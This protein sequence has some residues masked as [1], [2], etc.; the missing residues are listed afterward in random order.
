M[1]DPVRF[2]KILVAILKI[3]IVVELVGALWQ[4]MKNGDWGRFG[5][6][7]VI[8]GI[9]YVLWGRIVLLVRQKKEESRKKVLEP[10][11]RTRLWDALIFSLLWSDEIYGGIP[12]DRKRLVVISYTLIAIGLVAAFLEIGSGLMPLVIAGALVLAA[13]N[14][15]TW[16]VSLER[17]ERE[18]LQTEL[19]LAHDVQL[20]L[21]PDSHPR[22]DGLDAA[23]LSIPAKEVGGDHFNYTYVGP[24]KSVFGI[25]VFDVSGKGMHAAMEAVFTSGAFAS[26]V[27]QS[28]SPAE[29][30]TRLNATVCAHTKPG[31]FVTFLF[32][33]LALDK[34][35][36][37]F[38]NAG[39]VQPLLKASSGARWLEAAGTTFPLGVRA[40]HTYLNQIVPLGSQD[41][42]FLLSDGFTE[43]MND[44]MEPYGADRLKEFV[45][46]LETRRLSSQQMLDSITAEIRGYMVQAP[47]HDDMTM[48]VVK[49]L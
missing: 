10:S 17:G 29:T 20:S 24:G 21:M 3:L 45:D 8:A 27:Q 39:H 36:F 31:H 44:R 41:V 25:S 33:T 14:L 48:V 38:A 42:L 37:T 23:C 12:M 34:K 6:D 18:T 2:K 1:I 30:L 46:R 5:I 26:H 7:L 9:L 19:K 13:V 47:Q 15:L 43:A 49:I 22:V 40:D 28:L 35:V 16:V 4:G 11:Q 32:S